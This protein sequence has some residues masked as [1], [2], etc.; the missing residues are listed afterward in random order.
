MNFSYICTFLLQIFPLLKYSARRYTYIFNK[1]WYS[2]IAS[3]MKSILEASPWVP[4]VLILPLE[5]MCLRK[6]QHE[7]AFFGKISAQHILNYAYSSCI[8]K[9]MAKP[10]DFPWGLWICIIV[11]RG[12]AE[13]LPYFPYWIKFMFLNMFIYRSNYNSERIFSYAKMTCGFPP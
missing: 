7:Y 5:Y 1:S 3:A 11:V 9:T 4:L 10:K 13:I 2:V 8:K 12:S 6:K